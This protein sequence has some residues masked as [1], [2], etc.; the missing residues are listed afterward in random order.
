MR[1]FFAMIK[2]SGPMYYFEFLYGADA[3]VI[4]ME[5]DLMRF[6]GIPLMSLS[7]FIRNFFNNN[8]ENFRL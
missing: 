5:V 7:C 1:T 4:L 6:H 2:R 8:F 3:N